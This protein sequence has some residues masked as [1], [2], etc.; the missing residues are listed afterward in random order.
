MRSLYHAPI[1]EYSSHR[2]RLT[3]KV[4]AATTRGDSASQSTPHRQLRQGFELCVPYL[5]LCVL[6]LPHDWRL[7]H[8]QFRDDSPVLRIER[9]NG[10]LEARYSCFRLPNE[11]REGNTKERRN[12]VKKRECWISAHLSLSDVANIIAN[13][14]GKFLLRQFLDSPQLCEFGSNSLCQ[15]F[16]IPLLVRTD[17]LRHGIIFIRLTPNY[18][19]TIVPQ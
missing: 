11:L 5:R 4:V 7:V 10:L 18:S 14:I 19:V 3:Q 6:P 8:E 12:C 15:C 16:G 17:S 9:K 2:I 13:A 1:V